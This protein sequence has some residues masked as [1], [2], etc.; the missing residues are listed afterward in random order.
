MK[1]D[2]AIAHFGSRRALAEA[3]KISQAAIAQWEGEVPPLRQ[4][5][6][7][8]LMQERPKPEERTTP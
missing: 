7:R 5:Q 3:L 4:Y 6:I 2:D 8:E 1:L